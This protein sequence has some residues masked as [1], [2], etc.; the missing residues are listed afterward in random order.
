MFTV[1]EVPEAPHPRDHMA[2]QIELAEATDDRAERAA[3]STFVVVGE[4][5]TGTAVAALCVQYTEALYARHPR[6]HGQPPRWLPLTVAKGVLPELDERLSPRP[7]PAR[8]R[9]R[10][11]RGVSVEK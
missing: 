10:R 11:A 2:R 6:L 4:R 5:Y 1:V 8:A 7:G 9:R 3:R